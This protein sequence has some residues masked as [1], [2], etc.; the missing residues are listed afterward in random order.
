MCLGAL[1]SDEPLGA[2]H[3]VLCAGPYDYRDEYTIDNALACTNRMFR[4]AA[5]S[6]SVVAAKRRMQHT[7]FRCQD[8][9]KPEELDDALY[10]MYHNQTEVLELVCAFASITFKNFE[11]LPVNV[12]P[13]WRNIFCLRQH[14]PAINVSPPA[15]AAP[16][17]VLV[18]G[19]VL[20][21][22]HSHG[23][24][25]CLEELEF[26]F[27]WPRMQDHLLD[28]HGHQMHSKAAAFVV[29]HAVAVAEPSSSL[30]IDSR[31]RSSYRPALRKLVLKNVCLCAVPAPQ[32]LRI[33]GL[34]ALHRA[35]HHQRGLRSKRARITAGAGGWR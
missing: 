32:I 35:P 30:W 11:T 4:R 33:R 5:A 21:R 22:Y 12:G 10:A 7:V 24:L 13:A 3:A 27:A 26:D 6:R 28:S 8:I 9:S 29:S 14:P 34:P 25:P 18:H 19:H 20:E 23:G 15:G 16:H 2:H 1:P 17:R 31:R